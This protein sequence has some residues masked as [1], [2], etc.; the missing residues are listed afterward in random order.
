[1]DGAI[2]IGPWS[3]GL[4][5]LIGLV[6]GIGDIIGALVSMVIVVRGLGRISTDRDCTDGEHHHRHVGR[7]HPGVRR[8]VRL[9]VQVEPEEPA[10]LR[11]V[12]VW[13][14][15][16]TTARHFGFFIALFAVVGAVL[17]GIALGLIALVRPLTR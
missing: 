17:A 10:D 9:R 16:G 7:P 15:R 5:P 6:P 14:P 4:D 11:G 1:M 13:R 8:C 12:P 2:R 3:I